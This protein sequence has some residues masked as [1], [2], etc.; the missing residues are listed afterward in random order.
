MPSVDELRKRFAAKTVEFTATYEPEP[1]AISI[2]EMVEIMTSKKAEPPKVEEPRPV[3]DPLD[4]AGI[5]T[6]RLNVG[7]DNCMNNPAFLRG[8][9]VKCYA[10]TV[11]AQPGAPGGLER[12]W[13]PRGP[14]GL[15][16]VQKDFG[17]GMIVEFG[18]DYKSGRSQIRNRLFARCVVREHSHLVLTNPVPNYNDVPDVK[19]LKSSESLTE[20]KPA[21]PVTAAEMFVVAMR[22]MRVTPVEIKIDRDAIS[23]NMKIDLRLHVE[24]GNAEEFFKAVKLYWPETA[25]SSLT[26]TEHGGGFWK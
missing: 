20:P 10:A 24:Q 26:M 2:D 8:K 9:S 11:K 15:V 25:A 21:A 14:E 16:R 22:A 4:P 18:G 3:V 5:E 19:G 6:V 7:A 13:W 17:P 12:T 23:G 1:T